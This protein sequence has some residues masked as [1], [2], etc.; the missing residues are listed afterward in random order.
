M[1]NENIKC[2]MDVACYQLVFVEFKDNTFA[3]G[4]LIPS[5]RYEN[6][7]TILSVGPVESVIKT[8]VISF[9]ASNIK[10]LAYLNGACMFKGYGKYLIPIFRNECP[11]K[12]ARRIRI[13]KDKSLANLLEED[14]VFEENIKPKRFV[15][16]DTGA[17]IDL[18]T[19]GLGSW[20]QNCQYGIE[21]KG[22]KVYE[23]YWSYGGEWEDDIN[24]STLLGTIVYSSDKPLFINESSSAICCSKKPEYAEYG[25][26]LKELFFP[27]KKESSNNV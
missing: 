12:I 20:G 3:E 9:S 22:N 18:E 1:K 23:T 21:V 24:E 8:G 13:L 17:V 19:Y 25:A 5:K 2:T 4:W 16:L 15:V 26:N 11:E 14:I 10:Y 27:N 6:Y 7:Y